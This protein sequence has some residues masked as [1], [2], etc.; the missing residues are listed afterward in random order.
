[1]TTTYQRET[2]AEAYPDAKPLLE[3]HWEELNTSH[4]EPFNANLAVYEYTEKEGTLMIFTAR[5][6]GDL[7]GYSAVF[8]HQGLHCMG[9][10]QATQDV[11]Y[12]SPEHRGGMVGT[13]L[14]HT[15]EKHLKE[16]GVE[17]MMHHS[18]IKNMLLG[19]LLEALGYE[20]IA[21]NYQRR[22]G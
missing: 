9:Q 5:D 1:M 22:L 14:I 10:K 8:I 16:A 4:G 11:F 13:R 20:P 17:L 12:V 7:I 18:N 6:E 19:K 21:V 2:F 3:K 15:A